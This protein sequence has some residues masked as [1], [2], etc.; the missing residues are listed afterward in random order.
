MP[1]GALSPVA[2]QQFFDANGDPL[3]GGFLE[4]FLAGTMTPSPIYS[5]PALTIPLSNPVVLDGAGRAPQLFL[6]ALAYKFVLRDRQAVVVWTADNIVSPAATPSLYAQIAL[7]GLNHDV[8]VPSGRIALVEFVNSEPLD[9]DGF[10]DGTPGQ[11]LILVNR[12]QV[13]VNLLDQS[14]STSMPQNRLQNRNTTGPTQLA[15]EGGR[16]VYLYL[17]NA[18]LLLSIL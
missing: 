4:S 8:L 13:Q 17:N 6:A 5:D 2:I 11:F 14:V 16:A 12:G 7:N 15:P 3:A 9:I 18:W 1:V 10:A